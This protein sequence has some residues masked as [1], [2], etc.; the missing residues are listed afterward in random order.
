MVCDEI[1]RGHKS[2][3]HLSSPVQHPKCNRQSATKS[4]SHETVCCNA[5]LSLESSKQTDFHL[6]IAMLLNLI[7]YKLITIK[8]ISC[9]VKQ[10]HLR[11][12][13][14]SLQYTGMNCSSGNCANYH[15]NISQLICERSSIDQ[16]NHEVNTRNLC[17][18]GE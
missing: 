1:S 4:Q 12:N 9:T 11:I 16:L 5:I 10:S 7:A 18:S 8:Q 17:K 13:L 3:S 14:P 6:H 15:D 2:W